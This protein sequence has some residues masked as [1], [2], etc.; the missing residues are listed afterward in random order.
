MMGNPSS[1][2][3][4]SKMTRSCPR[5]S[6][7]HN[8]LIFGLFPDSS[9][10]PF[11]DVLGALE[12]LYRC[13]FK[14]QYFTNNYSRYHG[15]FWVFVVMLSTANLPWCKLIPVTTH[16]SC[17]HSFLFPVPV[18]SDTDQLH[19]ITIYSLSRITCKWKHTTF[20]V[21][22]VGFL[23]LNLTIHRF[24]HVAICINR[25]LLLFW[26]FN[27]SVFINPLMS[28]WGI[29]VIYS[30]GLLQINLLGTFVFKSLFILKLWFFYLNT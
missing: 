17:I 2:E 8:L 10:T 11:D 30:L 25:S 12:G 20:T 29:W 9:H 26:S 22:I 5:D 19:F 4:K 18:Q 27:V 28:S 7:P 15:Q 23:S 6:L 24:I 14:A 21:I 1:W 16:S 13:P 3:L